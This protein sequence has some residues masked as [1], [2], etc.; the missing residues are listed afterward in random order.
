MDCTAYDPK[1][2]AHRD[3]ERR[4]LACHDPFWP[5]VDLALLRE[6]LAL[7]ADIS[8]TQLQLAA[9][10]AVATAMSEFANWRRALRLRG[11]QRLSDVSGHAHG[12]ALSICFLRMVE[13][14]TRR[15]LVLHVKEAAA[16][17]PVG[18]RGNSHE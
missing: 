2:S 8:E 14:G 1:P 3:P 10:S 5:S 6:R 9:Q 15:A 11:Y 4:Y 17:D 18:T 7:R 13:A 16:S 12:L